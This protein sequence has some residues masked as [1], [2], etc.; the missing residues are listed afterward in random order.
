MRKNS[1]IRMPHS[2]TRLPRRD[3]HVTKHVKERQHKG[4]IAQ[5]PLGYR[6]NRIP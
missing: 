4:R 1:S 2:K 5:L 3:R 6:A